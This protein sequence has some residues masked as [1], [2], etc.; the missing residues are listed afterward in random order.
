MDKMERVQSRAIKWIL[1]EQNATYTSVEYFRKCKDLDLLPLKSKLDFYALLLFHKI[2]HKN[3]AIELPYYISLVSQ[4]RLR[5]SHN[6]PLTFESSIKPRFNKTIIAKSKK[7]SS[8]KTF[9]LKRQFKSVF[10]NKKKSKNNKAKLFFKKR[11]KSEK[12]YKDDNECSDAFSEMKVF[13]NSYFW[14]THI[15]WNNLPLEVKVIDNYETFKIKLETHLWDMV[16]ET[17]PAYDHNSS[18]SSIGL[19]GD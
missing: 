9:K 7:S 17:D 1:S 6:D 16:L 10:K 19:P 15:Q 13:K 5:S 8:N 2:I 3:I 18:E 4:S 11:K 14:R 12:I